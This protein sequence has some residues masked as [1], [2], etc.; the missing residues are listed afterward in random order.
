VYLYLT[1]T[2][3]SQSHSTK[4]LVFHVEYQLIDDYY[5]P[6]FLSQKLLK[7]NNHSQ[8]FSTSEQ[9][10]DHSTKDLQTVKTTSVVGPPTPLTKASHWGNELQKQQDINEIVHF[11]KLEDSGAG[12]SNNNN[13]N[14]PLSVQANKRVPVSL[15]R[16]G[17][18]HWMFTDTGQ[19]IQSLWLTD[20]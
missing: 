10:C 15:E 5:Y 14:T 17:Y 2:T 3:H 8:S 19:T 7:L 6:E 11:D 9:K 4:V 1:R 20:I 18:S 12:L 16:K 13:N